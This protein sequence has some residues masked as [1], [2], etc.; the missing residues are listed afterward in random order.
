[1]AS[2]SLVRAKTLSQKKSVSFFAARMTQAVTPG[3]GELSR[4]T[5]NYLL[6]NL[7]E[8]ALIT[9]A[10]IMVNTASDAA[11]SAVGTLGTTEAG[12]QILSA[13][14]LKVAGAQGTFTGELDTGTGLPLYLRVAVTGAVTVDADITVMVEYVEYEKTT[15]EYTRY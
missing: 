1:M 2:T 3:E 9:N 10:F 11:T 7:P 4:A 13:A 8:K 14:D 6:A 15:G 5:A 12:T